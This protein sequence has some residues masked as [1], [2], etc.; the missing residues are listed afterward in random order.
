M[1]SVYTSA[2]TISDDIKARLQGI[3]ATNGSET[4]IGTTVFMGRRKILADEEAPC[5]IVTESGDDLE[6]EAGR[7][8]S[9]LVKVSVEYQIDGYDACDPD[10]PNV[11][12]H[13]MIRDIKRAIFKGGDRTMGGKTVSVSYRG[14]DIGPRPDGAAFV[15]VRVT[16]RV[17]YAEDL[18]NP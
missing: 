2:E 3:L 6:D 10:N 11:K 9:A 12:A 7:Y 4:N 15:M 13:A 1:T 14:R 18:A 5:I 16:I 17:S 8:R